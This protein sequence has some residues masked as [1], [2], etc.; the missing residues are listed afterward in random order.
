MK[1][2]SVKIGRASEPGD[3]VTALNNTGTRF[4]ELS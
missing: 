2:D 3:K 4:T 1:Q